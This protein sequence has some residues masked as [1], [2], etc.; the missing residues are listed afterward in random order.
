[1]PTPEEVKL[2]KAERAEPSLPHIREYRIT[3]RVFIVVDFLG[4]NHLSCRSPQRVRGWTPIADKRPIERVQRAAAL[5]FS[6]VVRVET[7]DHRD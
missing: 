1:M 3:E 7:E 4:P 5:P 6:I 2:G